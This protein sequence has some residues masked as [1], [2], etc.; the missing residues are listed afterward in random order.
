MLLNLISY[1]GKKFTLNN[2]HINMRIS[3][4]KLEIKM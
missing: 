4:V 2:L 1:S 3:D